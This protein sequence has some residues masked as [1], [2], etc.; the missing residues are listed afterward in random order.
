[1]RFNITMDEEFVKRLDA[2][3]AE[4]KL[5]RAALL[6]QAA[7]EYMDAAEKLPAMR[8]LMS[9][10]AI[11]TGAALAGDISQDEYQVR[12]DDLEKQ[13]KALMKKPE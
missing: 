5:S 3:A 2:F 13:M 10:M 11:Q 7:A 9:G 4:K 12:L 1:M 8:A 6:R